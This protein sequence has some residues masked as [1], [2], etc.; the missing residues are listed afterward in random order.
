MRA[1]VDDAAPAL[2]AHAGQHE[3]RHADEA[4]DVGLELAAHVVER[5][6]LDR[7][8]LRVAGVVHEHADGAFDLLDRGDGRCID[9]SSVTSQGE[10][11][12]ALRLEIGDRLEAAGGRV[13][14]VPSLGEVL[15]RRAADAGRAA[16]DEDGLRD[17]VGMVG[18]LVSA[19]QLVMPVQLCC[20]ACYGING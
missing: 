11:L 17:V 5:H 15:G 4:E 9:A 8:V 16:G 19:S 2:L 1:D 6:L 7:A 12:A 3:L 20:S 18:L 13:D 14:V 10:H